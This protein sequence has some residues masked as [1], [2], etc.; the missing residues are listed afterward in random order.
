MDNIT[1]SLA[2]LVAGE[3]VIRFQERRG[4]LLSASA[5]RWVWG[6]SLLANNF[7]DFDI[8]YAR[9][10]SGNLGYLLHHRGH[11]H[12]IVGAI[13]QAGILLALVWIFSRW[14]KTE[15]TSPVWK[16]FAV[17]ALLGPL[18]HL[19]MD[20][21]NSYGV[22]PFWPL[23]NGWF[24]GDSIFIIEP[25]F[26]VLATPGLFRLSSSSLLR[27]LLIIVFAAGISLGTA[28]GMVPTSIATVLACAGLA[29]S[30]AIRLVPVERALPVTVSLVLIAFSVFAVCGRSVRAQLKGRLAVSDLI[31]TP[32]P[33]NPLCWSII[34]VEM[35]SRSDSYRLSRGVVATLPQWMPVDLCPELFASSLKAKPRR[36]AQLVNDSTIRWN[37]R[38][39]MTLS[40]L[41]ELKERCDVMGFLRFARAPFYEEREGQ[42]VLGD[43]RFERGASSF[44]RM[45]LNERV[46]KCP[47]RVP[48]WT[49]PIE[50]N[51]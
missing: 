34:A 40:H 6:V 12:T 30:L 27:A 1:H 23:M 31:L 48:A 21:T 44:S 46:E 22:H 14:R 49:P 20:A 39:E 36:L 24:Y 3:T 8:L 32:L 37:D 51:Y 41:E 42:I 5:R 13:P 19:A 38:F 2:G 50:R 7:P 47:Q 4:T 16:T 45:I 43:L 28:F 10:T 26:S 25:W 11:T 33:A 35:D 9:I 15:W 29:T 17:V 18:L